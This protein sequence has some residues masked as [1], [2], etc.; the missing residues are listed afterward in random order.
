MILKFTT[1]MSDI[2]CQ[3]SCEFSVLKNP[4]FPIIFFP[5][6]LLVMP[7]MPNFTH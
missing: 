3:A 4:K 6:L 5:L 2:I 7:K 1:I